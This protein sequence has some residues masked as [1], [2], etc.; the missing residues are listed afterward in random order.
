MYLFV[1]ILITENTWSFALLAFYSESVKSRSDKHRVP[2]YWNT[3]HSVSIQQLWIPLGC[4]RSPRS[5]GS[6]CR[7]SLGCQAGWQ[8]GHFL[9]SCCC[10]EVLG[11][12]LLG[13]FPPGCWSLGGAFCL[14]NLLLCSSHIS[15]SLPLPSSYIQGDLGIPTLL[16]ICIHH[17]L[18]VWAPSPH[19]TQCFY[20]VW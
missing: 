10:S 4:P 17:P 20:L 19:S 5:R 14:V 13:H 6:V 12:W 11:G 18:S 8:V 7:H 3:S 15:A 16:K 1:S 9:P 2:A